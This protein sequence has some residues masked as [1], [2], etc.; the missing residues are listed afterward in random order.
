MMRGKRALA[1]LASLVLAV[2]VL[3]VGTF[4]AESGATAP[5]TEAAQPAPENPC[6]EGHAYEVKSTVA[7]T[8][9]EDGYSEEVC[10]RCG[11][12]R[13]VPGEKALGHDFSGE[14][15]VTIEPTTEKDGEMVFTCTRDDCNETQTKTIPK[16]EK[17]AEDTNSG[18]N[19]DQMQN[20]TGTVNQPAAVEQTAQTAQAAQEIQN[21]NLSVAG[22]VVTEK[23]GTIQA[24]S[25]KIKFKREG[26]GAKEEITLTFDNDTLEA[27][28]PSDNPAPESVIAYT[29]TGTLK[30]SL[31]GENAVT[32]M[33]STYGIYAPEGTVRLTGEK[34]ATLDIEVSPSY[35]NTIRAKQIVVDKPLGITA[36][37]NNYVYEGDNGMGGT[38]KTIAVPNGAGGNMAVTTATIGDPAVADDKKDAA[39]NQDEEGKAE[40][41]SEDEKKD[42]TVDGNDQKNEEVQKDESADGNDQADENV[43][44]AE[45]VQKDESVTEDKNEKNTE[46][47][48]KQEEDA[49]K[50]DQDAATENKTADEPA[51]NAPLN[52]RR[53]LGAVRS[54]PGQGDDKTTSP[55]NLYIDGKLFKDANATGF[56]ASVKGENAD[57]VVSLTLKDV[58]FTATGTE[59]APD[60]KAII[61]YG[62]QG[63][64]SI[65]VEG[66]NTLTG[67]TLDRGI[68]APNGSIEIKGEKGSVLKVKVAEQNSKAVEAL[69]LEIAEP[70][71]IVEPED[72]HIFVAE[73]KSFSNIAY[74]DKSG[75]KGAG[76]VTLEVPQYTVTYDAN[77][78]TGKKDSE[79][80]YKGEKLN[81]PAKNIFTAPT[82][83]ANSVFDYWDINGDGKN[84]QPGEE[85]TIAGPTTVKAVWKVEVAHQHKKTEVPEKKATC[86]EDGVI[87]HYKCEECGKLFLDEAMTD[88]NEVTAGDSRLVLPKTGHKP[89]KVADKVDATC[90]KDG[91]IEYYECSECKK[92]FSDAEGKNEIKSS[93]TVIKAGHKLEKVEKQDKTCTKGGHIEHYKCSACGKLFSDSEGKNEIQASDV[94]IK[95]GHTWDMSPEGIVGKMSQDG[96]QV[97]YTF[98]CLNCDETKTVVVP[99]TE[100]NTVLP[101]EKTPGSVKYE[102]TLDG[103]KAATN[104][105]V[106]PAGT[107]GYAF[108]VP[109]RRNAAVWV[110]NSKKSLDFTIKRGSFD[111]ITYQEFQNGGSILVDNKKVDAKNYTVE[112]GSLKITLKPDYLNTLAAGTH[113]LHVNFGDGSVEEKFTVSATSATGNGTGTANRTA[114]ATTNR[115]ANATTNRTATGSP[116]TGD[117]SNWAL[118]IGLIA[119]SAAAIC[120]IVFVRKRGKKDESADNS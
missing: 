11:D 5:T 16:L 67:T 105:S 91:N 66:E 100:E 96:S 19:A 69:K 20:N 34:G 83:P 118:W 110:K 84:H 43:Q 8:C 109:Q 52:T 56:E 98:K 116:S 48:Q 29:G 9:T 24:G 93:D 17:K 115:T 46:D 103:K 7:P 57:E 40:D 113:T 36:P 42:E 37:E 44:K 71:E 41:Q 1:I 63:T 38:Y 28:V 51:Q 65:S 18:Q 23:K 33:G 86:T 25:S 106:N 92:L 80:I 72:G 76:S 49:E 108:T 75:E 13:R 79:E 15:R 81:L 54:L 102:T 104:L 32:G 62:G 89:K 101:T 95:A 21:T 27:K 85:I 59:G 12:T 14:G 64:L 10:S 82:S 45:E 30:I 60:Q 58:N 120:G 74:T 78:G 111:T 50:D 22:I 26:E 4:A 87:R 94:V 47:N 2:G 99:L 77:G 39:E 68:N 107:K 73:D 114:N 112:K 35:S 53:K 117:T 31:E 88:K 70:L 61:Y 3:S 119:V 55:S 6:A 90:T 97:T